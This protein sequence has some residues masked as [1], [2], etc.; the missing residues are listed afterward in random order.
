MSDGVWS[1]EFT[2]ELLESL[3]AFPDMENPDFRRLVLAETRAHLDSPRALSVSDFRDTRAHLLAIVN[4]CKDYRDPPQAVG[5]IVRTIGMLH[6][7]SSALARLETCEDYINGASALGAVRLR[8]VLELLAEISLDGTGIS[9]HDLIWQIKAKDEGVPLWGFEN[10]LQHVVRRLDSARTTVPV[11][12]PIVV[13]FLALLASNLKKAAP[14]LT[15]MVSEI[16]AALGLPDNMAGLVAAGESGDPHSV[17]KRVLRIQLKDE[18][19]PERPGFTIAGAVFAAYGDQEERIAWCA[20]DGTLTPIEAIEDAGSQYLAQASYLT[21]AMG[22]A[23]NPMVEFVLPWPL[24]GQPVERWR[25]NGG[26]KWIGHQF[27]VVVRSLDRPLSSFTS[28]KNRWDKFCGPD[29]GVA[30]RDH[31]GWLHHG[32][33]TIPRQAVEKGRVVSLNGRY[34]LITQWLEEAENCMTACLGLTFAYRP[35][36]QVGRESIVN[37]I[38]EGIPVLLWRRDNGDADA[39]EALLENVSIKDLPGQIYSWRRLTASCLPD[40]D[41]VRYHVVLLWDDPSNAAAPFKN[42]FTTPRPEDKHVH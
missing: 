15:V 21:D 35:D 32:E 16:C 37:A 10:D 18:S 34:G 31:I 24:L 9:I 38:D 30:V 6:P 40:T 29:A 25:L 3:A 14:Q 4:A 20:S 22:M 33:A 39:L 5:A 23:S 11:D 17:D 2:G 13:R 8:G 41:D 28:W 27:P 12:V 19:T 1:V 42:I 36:D 26:K 7:E